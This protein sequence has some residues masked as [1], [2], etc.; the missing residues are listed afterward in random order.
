MCRLSITAPMTHVSMRLISA[1]GNLCKGFKD[2]CAMSLSF[3]DVCADLIQPRSD[4]T[5]NTAAAE[6]VEKP[7]GRVNADLV[8]EA[9]RELRT[10]S[11]DKEHARRHALEY[12]GALQAA[13]KCNR[14]R[15]LMY[16]A[17]WTKQCTYV[18]D[19]KTHTW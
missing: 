9:P 11:P 19:G 18:V 1:P 17:K 14:C 7:N 8:V 13:K 4:V 15:W 10:R 2:P 12:G 6:A 3:W 5:D 16:K